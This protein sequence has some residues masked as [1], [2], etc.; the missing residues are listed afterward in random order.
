[1]NN[2]YV[3]TGYSKK[4][5]KMATHTYRTIEDIA[6]LINMSEGTVEKPGSIIANAKDLDFDVQSR[7]SH[8]GAEII[9]TPKFCW[10]V[11]LMK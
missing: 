8:G 2:K 1:M 7:S 5:Q 4:A 6:D 11:F 9:D 3:V 10:S